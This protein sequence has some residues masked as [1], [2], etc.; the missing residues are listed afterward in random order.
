MA[1]ILLTHPNGNGRPLS[2]DPGVMGIEIYSAFNAVSFVAG[3]GDRLG[4]YMRDSG[5]EVLY[6]ADGNE[7]FNLGMTEFKAGHI[8]RPR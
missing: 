8:T 1:H 6:F 3:N 7:P 4:V 5:F 2:I